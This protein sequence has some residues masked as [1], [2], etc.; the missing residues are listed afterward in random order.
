MTESTTKFSC[1]LCDF[2]GKDNHALKVHKT[3]KKHLRKIGEIKPVEQKPEKVAKSVKCSDCAFYG[4]SH[5]DLLRHEQTQKHIH[6]NDEPK[7]KKELHDMKC[8]F[9]VYTTKDKSNFRK[10]VKIH[11]QEF[12]VEFL[13]Q[14]LRN[15]KVSYANQ[16]EHYDRTQ[17]E[18]RATRMANLKE[19]YT[20]T[21]KMLETAEKFNFTELI[22]A[23][24]A[25][26]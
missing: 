26:N 11:K 24:L 10:H 4:R 3:S 16:K 15:T 22:N 8:P 20:K 18:V 1:D 23:E 19:H 13:K 2:H 9:C 17:S 12:D 6:R 21:K 7:V 5:T 25:K 14:D